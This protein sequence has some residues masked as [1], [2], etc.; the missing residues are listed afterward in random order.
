VRLKVGNLKENPDIV[1]LELS[2]SL[3]EFIPACQGRNDVRYRTMSDEENS[4]S[5]GPTVPQ[6]RKCI[7]LRITL[8]AK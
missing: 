3:Q 6:K 1:K 8:R 2:G 4:G 7:F 5:T